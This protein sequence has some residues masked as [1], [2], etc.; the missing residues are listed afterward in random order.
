MLTPFKLLLNFCNLGPV[1]KRNQFIVVHD[2]SVYSKPDG[3][4]LI[5]KIYYRVVL[6]L[7]G[8]R[9]KKIITVSEFSKIELM[10]F[11]KYNE[12]KVEVNLSGANDFSVKKNNISI[13]DKFNLTS[14]KYLFAVGSMNP[15]KNFRALLEAIKLLNL[16]DC[17][18]VISGGINSKIFQSQAIEDIP[19][20]VIFTGY[21]SDDELNSLYANALCFVFPSIYEGFGFPPLEAMSVGCPVIVSNAAS[22]PEVCSDAALYCNPYDVSDIASKIQFM[23]DN[24]KL[25]I[26][27]SNKGY[28]RV[29]DLDWKSTVAEVIK[30]F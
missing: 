27:Y 9:A 25:Q 2:A 16:G 29:K 5:F 11:C 30:L 3:Y 4:S 28:A 8:L 13:L 10:K 1:I 15:N 23:I 26:I 14:R 21:V 24:P 7:I 17:K 19:K 20:S 22:L 6:S 18:F 12:K